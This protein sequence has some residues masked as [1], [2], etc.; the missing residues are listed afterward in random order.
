MPRGRHP[1]AKHLGEEVTPGYWSPRW[2]QLWMLT[3]RESLEAPVGQPV[4]VSRC[5][6]AHARTS[7]IIRSLY[8]IITSLC[9]AIRILPVTINTH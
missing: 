2:T 8:G 3:V 9:V 4:A 7:E 6:T 1:G 5:A